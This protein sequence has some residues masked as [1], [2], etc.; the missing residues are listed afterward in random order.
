MVL[1]L[2]GLCWTQGDRG[3]MF[4]GDVSLRSGEWLGVRSD[5]LFCGKRTAVLF[6]GRQDIECTGSSLKL[7]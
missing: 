1:N 6:R 7:G 5:I 3:L 4:A 2:S